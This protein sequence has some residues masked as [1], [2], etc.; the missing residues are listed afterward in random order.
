MISGSVRKVKYTTKI[1]FYS[2]QNARI[3]FFFQTGTES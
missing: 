3:Y 2:E 1:Y